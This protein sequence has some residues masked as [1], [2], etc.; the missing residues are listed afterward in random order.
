MQEPRVDW[1]KY[2]E[3][4]YG[5]FATASGG[6]RCGVGWSLRADTARGL[7]VSMVQIG[8][9]KCQIS[10]FTLKRQ[11]LHMSVGVMKD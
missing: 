11:D 6:Y 8:T 7:V 10:L 1:G 2:V 9:Y 5:N 3:E 4:T